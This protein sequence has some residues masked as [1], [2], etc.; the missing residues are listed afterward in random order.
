MQLADS[1]KM[2]Y[3]M[4]SVFQNMRDILSNALKETVFSRQRSREAKL[5]VGRPRIDEMSNQIPA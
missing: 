2:H 3:L 4:R 1:T 5:C